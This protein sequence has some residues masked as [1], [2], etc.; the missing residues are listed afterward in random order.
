MPAKK[1]TYGIGAFILD[2]I[3]LVELISDIKTG[4]MTWFT[5]LAFLLFATILSYALVVLARQ[6][7]RKERERFSVKTSEEEKDTKIMQEE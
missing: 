4:R 6:R 3:L 7:R 2:C 5:L 1:I